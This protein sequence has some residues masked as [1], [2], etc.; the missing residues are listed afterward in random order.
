M[1]CR[2]AGRGSSARPGDTQE[3]AQDRYRLYRA[4]SRLLGNRLW[5]PILPAALSYQIQPGPTPA[6]NSLACL[7]VKV[8]A[9]EGARHTA[10]AGVE[11]AA[12]LSEAVEM[13]RSHQLFVE[14]AFR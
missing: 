12:S 7:A 4:R 3:S 14:Q 11:D 8:Q 1:L 6:S 5:R 10:W 2:Y 9:N 13:G